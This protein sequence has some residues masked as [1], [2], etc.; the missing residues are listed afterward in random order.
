MKIPSNLDRSPLSDENNNSDTKNNYKPTLTPPAF[1]NE[2]DIPRNDDSSH[3]IT[4]TPENKKNKINET[5]FIQTPL[6]LN[7]NDTRSS[8]IDENEKNKALS[9]LGTHTDTTHT[10]EL[11]MNS[12]GGG[13][14]TGGKGGNFN[15]KRSEDYN[16]DSDG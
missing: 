9:E 4:Q 3:M 5:I 15:D 10:Q 11:H 2:C 7:D 16:Y 13:G 14:G 12:G 8:Y 1:N 6:F